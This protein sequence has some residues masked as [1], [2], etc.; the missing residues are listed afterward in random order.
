VKAGNPYDIHSYEDMAAN[1]EVRVG[2][3]TG[4]YEEDYALEAGVPEDRLVIFPDG[5][6]GIAGL[7]SDRI[8]VLALNALAIQVLLDNENDPNLERA[9]PFQD[10]IVDGKSVRGCGGVGFRKEDSDLR[11]AFN[12]E[13][14]NLKE[15]GELLDLIEPFGFTEGELPDLTMEQ[16]CTP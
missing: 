7:Q 13:L 3:L 6:S 12:E 8:D 14:A 16:L 15:S 2:V 4:A 10:P 11:D 1:P 5:P 9:L